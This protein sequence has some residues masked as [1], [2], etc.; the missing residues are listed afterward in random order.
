MASKEDLRGRLQRLL[1]ISAAI[2]AALA[3]AAVLLMNDKTYQL[4]LG[5]MA[6]DALASQ[7]GS[8]IL[9]PASRA[10]ADFPLKWLVAFIMG[11]SSLYMLL[12][13]TRMRARYDRDLKANVR[14]PRWIYLAVT[15]ALMLEVVALLSGINDL[16]VLK[17]MAGTLVAAKLLD[18]HSEQMNKGGKNPVLFTFGLSLFLGALPWIV[19][20]GSAIGTTVFGM[21]RFAWYVYA[22]YAAIIAAMIAFALNMRN[23]F[24]RTGQWKDYHYAERNYLLIDFLSKAAFAIILIIGLRR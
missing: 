18:W 1:T 10:L 7:T 3:V 13:A 2:F 20:L 16:M 8:S 9:A 19:I 17:L 15:G 23:Q 6:K 14:P 21:E 12:T 11:L 4:T 24:R 5:H 22:L